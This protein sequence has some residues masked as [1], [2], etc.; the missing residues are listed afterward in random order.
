MNMKRYF[1]IGGI[2]AVAAVVSIV[3]STVLANH[4]PVIA[5]LRA[6]PEGVPPGG[7]CQVVCNATASGDGELSYSWSA[8]QGEVT[9]TEEEDT[10]MWTAPNSAG[11]YNVTVTVADSHGREV[12]SQITIPV[13]AND[14]PTITNLT[15]DSSWTTPS[16]II[17]VTCTASDPDREDVLS[18][19]WTADGGTISGSGPAVNWTAPAGV[20]AYDITVVVKDGYGGE[21]VGKLSL[22]VNLGIPPTVEK[23]VVTPVSNIYLRNSAVAGCNFDVYKDKQYTIECVASNVSGDLSYQW[24]STDGEISGQGQT[25]TWIS[26]DKLSAGTAYINVTVTLT[27]SDGAGNSIARNVVFHMA[28][29]TCGSWP[30]KSGGEVLFS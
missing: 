20:G 15:A 10:I 19:Q 25:I 22:S 26:P 24:S 5:S 27:V 12:T 9:P 11:S 6:E 16:G 21:A 29:C 13:R 7:I 23:L 2:V 3:L 17:Q 4:G 1:I 18:Y 8:T 28:S 30:L 14:A